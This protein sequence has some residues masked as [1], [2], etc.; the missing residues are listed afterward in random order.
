MTYFSVP[1][2]KKNSHRYLFMTRKLDQLVEMFGS[3]RC[4]S[5]YDVHQDRRR[6]YD[7]Q[8]QIRSFPMSP[9]LPEVD[10]EDPPRPL[11]EPLINNCYHSSFFELNRPMRPHNGKGINKGCQ[12]GGS[13][14]GD[15]K[16]EDTFILSTEEDLDLY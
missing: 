1:S 2:S 15:T 8:R 11:R 4:F 14:Q 7:D 3:R 6:V 16:R 10:V 5:D 13:F 12:A 9:Q